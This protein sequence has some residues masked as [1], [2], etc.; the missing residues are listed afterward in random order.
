MDKKTHTP[1]PLP[2]MTT[3]GNE[4]LSWP[5]LSTVSATSEQERVLGSL[6]DPGAPHFWT[7]LCF[8]RI[9]Y[10]VGLFYR[11]YYSVVEDVLCSTLNTCRLYEGFRKIRSQWNKA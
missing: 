8:G 9:T 11:Y 4:P 5:E 6:G 7:E 10:Q 2:L 3:V 1:V